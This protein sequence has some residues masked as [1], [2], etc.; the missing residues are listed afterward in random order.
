MATK[1]ATIAAWRERIGQD[2]R[3]AKRALLRIYQEQEAI[4][5]EAGETLAANGVGFTGHDAP[6]LTSLAEQV[7]A[8]RALSPKQVVALHRIMPKYTAQL[9]RLTYQAEGV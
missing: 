8:G 6:F 1:K 9:Y 3:W 7:E 2:E 4:E 5:V